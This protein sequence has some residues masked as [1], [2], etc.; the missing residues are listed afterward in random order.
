PELSTEESRVWSFGRA[1]GAT[2]TM[3]MMS[4]I[5]AA[6]P[7]RAFAQSSSLHAGTV[8]MHSSLEREVFSMLLC[9]CGA[10]ARLPLSNCVC[11]TADE[12]RA[13]VREQLAAGVDKAQIYTNYVAKYGSKALSVPPNTGGL[14]AIFIVPLLVIASGGVGAFFVLRRWKQG[15]EPV[16]LASG[17]TPE[18]PD[19]EYD[20]R[21]DDELRRMD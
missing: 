10:C 7:A 21:L 19:E 5:V 6:A 2:A 17:V 11:S 15:G 12:E 20:R 9:Q 1:I 4:V 14:R 16:A 13:A 3:V 18:S 8:E